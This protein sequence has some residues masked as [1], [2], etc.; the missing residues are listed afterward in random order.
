MAGPCFATCMG[1]EFC[2][3]TFAQSIVERVI[4][5]QVAGEPA[6]AKLIEI[7]HWSQ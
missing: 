1:G 6:K 3:A 5:K 2:G 4:K 7:A